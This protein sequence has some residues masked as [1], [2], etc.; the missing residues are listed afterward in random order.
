ML[1]WVCVSVG[2]G[3]V[4][5]PSTS[6]ALQ[7]KPRTAQQPCQ[8]PPPQPQPQPSPSLRQRAAAAGGNKTL[9]QVRKPPAAVAL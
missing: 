1:V 4:R 8:F 6:N 7:A 2:A 5:R 9:Q 3:V